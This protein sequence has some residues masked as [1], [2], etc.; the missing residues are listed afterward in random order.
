MRKTYEA[1]IAGL[2]EPVREER[3]APL[4]MTAFREQAALYL[5]G[6]DK[7]WLELLFLPH[8]NR[9]VLNLLNKYHPDPD[10]PTVYPLPVLEEE[11]AEPG[12]VLPPYLQ[13][14]IARFKAEELHP[15][16]QKPENVLSC[17][18]YDSLIHSGNAFLAGYAAF[19]LN[20]KNLSAALTCKK[21]GK[22]LEA[23]IVGEN[24]FAQALKT[25]RARDF[26]LSA[27]YPWVEQVVRLMENENLTERERGLDNLVWEYVEEQTTFTYFSIDRILGLAVQGMIVER[28]SRMD[29]GTGGEIFRELIEKFKQNLVIN[30]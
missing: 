22:E 20:L 13:D 30:T 6:R 12:Q 14:F 15:F 8:D 9:Q 18:Y 28:W 11:V 19:S 21:Y 17:L 29:P 27:E 24:Q 26:G 4:T 23:E 1:F 10:A 2:P 3:K 5:S 25:S 16:G 7:A